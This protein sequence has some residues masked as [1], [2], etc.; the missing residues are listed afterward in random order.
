MGAV[1]ITNFYF[2]TSIALVTG[3]TY[4][5]QPVV[6]SG[7]NPW[8]IIALDSSYLGGGLYFGGARSDNTNLWFREGVVPEPSTL[9]LVGLGSLLVFVFKRRSKSVVLFATGVLFTAAILPVN[10]KADSLV[11]ITADAAGLSPVDATEIPRIGTFWV[12]T[13]GADGR[14]DGPP[15]PYLPPK[16]SALPTY[17][18][19]DGIFI[20]DDTGGQIMPPSFGRLSSAQAASTAQAQ[21]ESLAGLI[22]LI[23]NPKNSRNGGVRAMASL[24]PPGDGDGTNGGFQP[25]GLIPP[26]YTT[27]DLYLSITSATNGIAQLVIHPPWNEDVS[28]DRW[29]LFYTTNLATPFTN[30]WWILTTALGQTN[31]TVPNATDAQGFYALGLAT[32]NGRPEAFGDFLP[33]MCPNT[34]NSITLEPSYYPSYIILTHPTN[35]VLT[36]TG[37]YLTYTP[38]PCF[39]NGQ[40][41]FVYKA[42][43]GTNDSAP[44]TVLITVNPDNLQANP[45]AAQTCHGVA[46][47]FSLSGGN[48]AETASFVV[49]TPAHGTAV[50]VT[51]F[52][53]NKDYL[54]TPT[55]TNFAGM[56]TFSYIAYD[57][58]GAVTNTVTI[59]VGASSI[60]PTFQAL[61]T[62]TNQSKAITLSASSNNCSSD[63][64]YF[65]YHI[66]SGSGPSHGTLTG[67]GTSR[68]YTPDLNYEGLDSFDFTASDGAWSNTAT[69]NIAVTAGPILFQD[70]NP[71]STAVSLVWLLDTN[72]QVMFPDPNTEIDD[73]IVY[74]SATSGGPYTAIATNLVAVQTNWMSYLDTNAVVGQ[75]NYYVVT[76][77]TK[78]SLSHLSVESPHSNEVKAA[79]EDFHPLIAADAFWTVQTNLNATNNLTLLQAPFSSFGTNGYDGI[80]PLPHT[81]WPVGSNWL[82]RITLFI[83]SNSVPLSQVSYS[84]AIDNGYQ[85]FLNNVTT[86]ID[87][88]NRMGD[89]VWVPYRSFESVAPGVLHYGT[90][91]LR[92]LITDDGVKNYFSM[93]VS[94]NVCGH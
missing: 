85:V 91:D 7:D 24:S 17:S 23:L 60:S 51:G 74:R 67:S 32:T 68:T 40:D 64:N 37:P 75:T 21:A 42:N 3:Q 44:A 83:P 55:D 27:N 12:M 46:Q 5:L 20:V 26:V 28:T 8:D 53:T 65:T 9:V 48:C 16:F 90:N 94:T 73:F 58:C 29:N 14:L 62:G 79:G 38:N 81:V 18:V 2:P 11:Q 6:L 66:V 57:N 52:S 13:V 15:Y 33:P 45:V 69:I 82:N 49:F 88:T 63:T 59:R 41:S 78:D 25:N 71:F 92:V 1:G 50:N 61:V 4:Y 84:I 10:A 30:W 43:D 72:E 35:G 19:K 89:A 70:C 22:D 77:H 31:L 36:G 86:A 39:E 56:D 76:F 80:A 93:I 47:S 54:Y 34:T 87:T